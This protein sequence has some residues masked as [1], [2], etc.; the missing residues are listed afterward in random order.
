K[1]EAELHRREKLYKK[2]RKKANFHNKTIILTDDGLA[3]GVTAKAAVLAIKTQN[4]EK[5]VLAVPV[6]PES[7]VDEFSKLVD[8][9]VYLETSTEFR[10]VGEFYRNFVQV[11]DDEVIELLSHF[12]T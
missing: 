8:E 3:T 7:A 11:S 4:P 5:V 2:D 10:S 6:C 12:S 1:E 9:F